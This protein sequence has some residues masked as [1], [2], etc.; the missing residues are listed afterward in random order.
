MMRWSFLFYE[1]VV[2]PGRVQAEA[3]DHS[4]AVTYLMRADERQRAVPGIIEA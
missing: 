1:V 2:E 3:V 4:F